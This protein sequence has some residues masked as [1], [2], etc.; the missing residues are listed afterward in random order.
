MASLLIVESPAKCS[1]IQGFLGPGWKVI[2]TMGHIRALDEGLEAV[3]LDR[4]FD[5]RYV[6]LK[7]KGKAIQQIKA[8]AKEAKQVYLASDDDREGEAISLSVAVLLDLPIETTPR[9]VFHEITKDAITTALKNPKRI[10]MN[11]AYAQQGRAI[12]DMM[13]GFTISPLLWKFVGTGLSAGRCQ[14]PALRL[15][16]ERESSI[17]DFKSETTWIVSG[18]WNAGS[19]FDAKLEDPLD[20]QESAMNYLENINTDTDGLVTAVEQRE[21]SASAPKPLITSTLQQ[22][23]S[24]LYGSQPKR[25]MQIAQRLYESGYITYMRTDSAGLSEESKKGAEAYVRTTYGENYIANTTLRASKKK[26]AGAQEAHEAIRPT[27]IETIDLP[28]EEDW[29]AIDRKIYKLIWNRTIQS[30]MAPCKGEERTVHFLANG[31][32]NELLWKAVWERTLFQGWKKVAQPLADLDED[33]GK[34]VGTA[35]SG[36]WTLGQNLKEGSKITWSELKAGPKDTKAQ[37]RYTEATLVR[38]LERRG[39]GRP[40]TFASLVGTIL[41]KEYVAKRDSPP[42][43]VV[44]TSYKVS[45]MGQWPPTKIEAVKKVGAEKNK[46]APTD[47][48]RSAIEFCVREFESLFDYGFTKQMEE[49]LDRISDGKEFWKDLC[50][51]TWNSFKEHYEDLKGQKGSQVQSART[52]TFESGIKAVQSKKGPILLIESANKDDTVFYGWPEG[53]VFSKIT[54]EIATA[55]VDKQKKDRETSSL[56]DCDGKPMI[57]KTGPFGKYVVCDKVNIP[58]KDGDTADMI[59]E[60]IKEKGES[61]LHTIGDFEFRRGPY[62]IYMFKKQATGKSRQFVS[63]P[64]NVDPKVLT[65]EAAIK[66]YQTGLQQK[67]KAKAFKKNNN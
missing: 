33:D 29:S 30:V 36:A 46:L 27:H 21:T 31:D 64:S 25:T 19:S 47:L 5:P 26:V 11:R 24:A 59:R 20:D 43:E 4:D 60:R 40:S 57:L 51:D 39:I 13:V 61:V 37:G 53:I 58:W 16:T 65:P 9:I 35:P 45:S 7:D 28:D 38:E 52:I 15:V 3:G 1:K 6:F 44:L 32:P 2:A 66:I 56:G 10:D 18:T 23:A 67:A 34:E 54:E 12:L 49:R 48:G 14:T 22:E 55:H 42:K 8:C 62:G 50:R 41:D 17:T 63:V